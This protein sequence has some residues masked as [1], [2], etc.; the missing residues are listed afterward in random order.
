MDFSRSDHAAIAAA[1]GLRSWRVEEPRQLETAL[2]QA[3]ACDGPSLV[4]VI[5]QPLEQAQAPVSEWIA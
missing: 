3:I 5:T 1:Y 4:D 2:R